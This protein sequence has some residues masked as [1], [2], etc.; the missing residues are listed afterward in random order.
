[1]GTKNTTL[2]VVVVLL[3]VGAI[4]YLDGASPKNMPIGGVSVTPPS[5]FTSEAQ[6]D[7]KTAMTDTAMEGEMKTPEKEMSTTERIAEKAKHYTLAKELINPTGFINTP[8]NGPV[9]LQ[10]LIGKKVILLDIWT[11]SCINCQR[12]IPYLRSWHDK[13]KDKGF[14]IIGLHV[15]E[16]EF[17]KDY[18][19][20]VEAVK[21]LGV[22]WPV[23]L[24]NNSN[25]A[26]AY[27]MRYWPEEYLID[28]D[29]FI[30]HKSIGEGNYD[31]TENEIQ[32]LLKERLDVLGVEGVVDET[33]T[34]IDASSSPR[35]QSPETY[36]G[37]SRNELLG[38]GTAGVS[39]EK[40]FRLPETFKLNT[41]YFGGQWNVMPEYA[42]STG[43]NAHIVFKYKARNVYFVARSK[44]SIAIEVLRDG[45]PLSGEKGADI[46][47]SADTTKATISESR[48]YKLIENDDGGE[49]TL[50]LIVP[51][52][53]LE[54][55]TFTFG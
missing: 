37:S 3:I 18:G 36:F 47:V 24:D 27:G 14:E 50:H 54:A 53:G 55:Y 17:E 5:L 8:D 31:V 2:L 42:K 33:I 29:G 1:M 21:K 35:A 22:T 32:K 48:L 20:V 23:V 25:T 30:V 7:E 52:A 19:N 26:R 41:L 34:K 40:T 4:I 10:N 16:F 6:V 46:S 13:Y 51:K 44:P 43:E 11:Y 39:G 12:T 9:T 38:N 28:I 49:H 45:V 15:P